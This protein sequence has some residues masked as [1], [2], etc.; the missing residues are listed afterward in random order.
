MAEDMYSSGDA[1]PYNGLEQSILS[2]VASSSIGDST[3]KVAQDDF[4]EELLE[5]DNPE[6]LLGQ[7]V[8]EALLVDTTDIGSLRLFLGQ[9]INIVHGPEAGQQLMI[10]IE[11]LPK[12]NGLLGR[13]NATTRLIK[14][15]KEDK[16]LDEDFPQSMGKW[17]V[18][19]DH[20]NIYIGKIKELGQDEMILKKLKM[21]L[22]L[23][24]ENHRLQMENK[25]SQ[26]VSDNA[27]I[28]RVAQM[29][30]LLIEPLAI[31]LWEETMMKANAMDR[32]AVIEQTDGPNHA[33]DVAY[34]KL[35]S[36]SNSLKHKWDNSDLFKVNN[37]GTEAAE[38]LAHIRPSQ[39]TFSSGAELQ[40]L[41]TQ[42]VNK[43]DELI[44][45]LD[46]SGKSLPEGNMERRL[47]CYATFIGA[48]GRSKNLALYI[49]FLVW[50]CQEHK[51]KSNRINKGGNEGGKSTGNSSRDLSRKEI[52]EIEKLSVIS[53]ALF[54][55]QKKPL[56]EQGV[57]G[58][59]LSDSK[60]K[61]Y[62]QRTLSEKTS[63]LSTAAKDEVMF[64]LLSDEQKQ[65]MVAK[66]FST[67]M[68]D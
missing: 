34:D 10:L 1:N 37:V 41:R 62:D 24:F 29:A 16:H 67:T 19:E 42:F 51:W 11:K 53:K 63:R 55:S 58:V 8:A 31:P 43:H 3:D 6:E 59:S 23:P 38:A 9:L 35:V 54:D 20:K 52:M 66:W 15:L 33:R 28:N 18:K 68:T 5:E 39:G 22:K 50:E 45:N 36:I 44:Q 13:T 47:Q 12:I 60:R 61:F 4:D 32:P 14:M 17:K 65:A 26:P 56:P 64:N 40:S 25:T 27:I 21:E 30:F 57:D 2:S 48:T 46:A 49:C 7:Q